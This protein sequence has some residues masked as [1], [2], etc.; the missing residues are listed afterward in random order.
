MSIYKGVVAGATAGLVASY[1]MNQFQSAWGKLLESE[2]RSHGAQSLQQGSPEHGIGR[3]LAERGVDEPADDATMRTANAVSELVL[4]HHLAKSEKHKAGAIVHYGFGVST[5][6]IYGA[7]AEVMPAATVCEGTAF[8]AAVWLLAD[9]GMVPA[10]GLS[11]KPT[12]Y[13]LSVHTHAFA[14]HIVYGLT[15]ELVRR[16][17]L[18]ALNG[19]A[20]AH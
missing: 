18:K 14:A 7:V 5:G 8:G 3:E 19:R 10:L 1:V 20:T 6:A 4:H 2:E 15:T 17:V 9:E 16:A 11:R 13:P 12:D